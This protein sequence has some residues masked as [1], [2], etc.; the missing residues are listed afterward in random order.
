MFNNQSLLETSS[1]MLH[2]VTRVYSV[3]KGAVSWAPAQGVFSFEVHCLYFRDMLYTLY[4]GLHKY[5]ICHRF[6]L[7]CKTGQL[8]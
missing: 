1:V 4:K 8:F 7:M 5:L 6:F 3:R 2:L